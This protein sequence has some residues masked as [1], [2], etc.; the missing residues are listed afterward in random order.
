MHLTNETEAHRLEH[1][2][3]AWCA[4]DLPEGANYRGRRTCGDRCRQARHRA[5][6]KA[7]TT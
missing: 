5:Q 4:T 1:N 7:G 3:C 6:R 2:L